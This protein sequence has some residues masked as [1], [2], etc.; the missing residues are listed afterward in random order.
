LKSLRV[1]T[2][3]QPARRLNLGVRPAEGASRMDVAELLFDRCRAAAR[4]WPK[5]LAE[6]LELLIWAT[7]DNGAEIMRAVERWLLSDDLDRVRV[8]VEVQEVFPFRHQAEMDA[9]LAVVK[10]RWP[11]LTEQCDRLSAARAACV[12]EADPIPPDVESRVRRLQELLREVL[13]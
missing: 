7:D 9:A 3:L 11:E 2:S 8:A 5:G 4:T 1:V 10:A 12:R 6:I 13:A